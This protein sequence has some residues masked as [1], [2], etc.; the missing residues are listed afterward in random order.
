MNTK[1]KQI[2]QV[3]KIRDPRQCEGCNVMATEYRLMD[4]GDTVMCEDCFDGYLQR[5]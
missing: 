3:K 1:Q 4:E 5:L 2:L